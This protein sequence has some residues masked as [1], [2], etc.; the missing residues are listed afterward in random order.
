MPNAK[1]QL[2][3]RGDVPMADQDAKA[4][5]VAQRVIQF[6]GGLCIDEVLEVYA[7]DAT[8]DDPLVHVVGVANIRAQFVG[9]THMCN[10]VLTRIT[11]APH[12]TNI[13]A[14]KS[15]TSIVFSS[16]QRFRLRLPLTTL[17]VSVDTTTTLDVVADPTAPLGWRVV[18]HR[19]RWDLAS[20]LSNMP[21]AAT[22][23]NRV[24]RPALGFISSVVI[25]LGCSSPRRLRNGA[26]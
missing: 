11:D 4:V 1:L 14:P 3:S 13:G 5:Q 20:V 2:A 8:F 25:R 26:L 9:L 19:D 6:Y 16:R 21:L 17:P 7:V 23:Y 18:A 10:G 24:L 22:L 12:F 15:T